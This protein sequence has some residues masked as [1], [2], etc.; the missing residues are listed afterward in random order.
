MTP[1]SLFVIMPFGIRPLESGELHDFDG[2]YHA[3]LRPLAEE[4]GFAVLRVDEV[5]QSGDITDQAFKYLM[6]SDVVV[7]DV[8][9]PNGNVYYELGIRQA[10][11][12]G[13]TILVAIRGTSL[14]F[15][16]AAQRVL[17]Y[18]QEYQ[19]DDRFRI[20][21]GSALSPEQPE[22]ISRVRKTLESMGLSLNRTSDQTTFE[23]EFNHK[24]ERAS[25]A[26]QLVAVWHWAKNFPSLPTSGLLK[27]SAKLANVGDFSS[28]A[29]ALQAGYPQAEDDYEVH[30]Q[31][32]F[33]LR[34]LGDYE[35]A[36]DELNRA[37][38]LNPNDPEALGML[39]GLYK[40]EGDYA[41]ALIC[42][43]RGLVLSPDSL[44]L[45]VAYAGNLLIAD[46]AG[47]LDAGLALYRS[48]SGFISSNPSYVGDFW[49]DLVLAEASFA[50]GQE[51]I[52][53]GNAR[54]AIENGAGRVELESTAEQILLIGD[55]GVNSELARRLSQ[56]LMDAARGSRALLK[57]E[58]Q[59]TS[60]ADRGT[61]SL[62]SGPRLI[63]HLSDIHFGSKLG[64]G[65]ERV[66]MHRFADSE[67]SRRL[68]L[69]MI[70]EMNRAMERT[71]CNS[72]DVVI[73]ISGD[74]T[75]TA[76][77]N[78]FKLVSAF[79]S[80]TCTTVGIRPDQV[81]LI[82]G[83]HDVNWA[84]AQQNLTHRFDDYL[85][86]VHDFYGETLF[87]KRFP[88]IEWNFQVNGER[89]KAN[90]IIYFGKHAD[91][92]FVGLN[93]CVFEDYQHHYGFVG[94]AQLD[95]VTALLKDSTALRFAVMHHHLLPYPEPLEARS[96]GNVFLD[97]STVRD[98]GLVE[99]RLEKL[100]FSL[101][102]HG[103][104]HK[105]QFR[106]SLVLDRFDES[107][108]RRSLLISG[109]GSTGVSEEELEQ[110]QSNHYA[111]IEPL[112]SARQPAAE[113]LRIEWRELSF[114]ADAEWAT[115]A[116]RTI[117]G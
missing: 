67:N 35:A 22:P 96:A 111:I 78:E 34:K 49:A 102:M 79:L 85:S 82:P 18:E 10:I 28:A 38:T 42:Y 110:S 33:Y 116:R 47:N 112:R 21:F 4:A 89:P 69:E 90:E 7:A 100:G 60:D 50:L 117:N 65:S 36:K 9:S 13:R 76:T 59:S 113:F 37:L 1:K 105:P 97:M 86:F 101:V 11:S 23:Q 107:D 53:F 103:H 15:D 75:Y 41:Q 92:T 46:A 115:M 3:L 71:N 66:D 19:H 25:T 94:R 40:R 99:K 52:A 80:E 32:G 74:L 81:V 27:L 64:N 20:L 57:V 5:V 98:A 54:R 70:D 73:V 51:A 29:D 95:K 114:A 87:R 43:E 61:A 12:S 44:Y 16:I 30:R 17:F 8:S 14:P 104:K 84:A 91:V 77:E 83:N 6:N 109:C 72:D 93:T 39:G 26:E 56:A 88:L 55:A 48:L 24:I 58:M 63:F 108:V 106:E 62:V 2:F 31:R 68:S 45:R